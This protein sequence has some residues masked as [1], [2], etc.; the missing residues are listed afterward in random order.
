[1]VRGVPK[2]II[3]SFARIPLFEGLSK[4]ALSA[5]AAAA[6][7][8]DVAAG[9]VIVRE[10][11]FDRFLYVLREGQAAVTRNGRRLGTMGPGDF[12]GELAFLSGEPRSA[13]VTASTPTRL[14]I[15]SPREM[16]ALIH[17]EPRI[18]LAM[19]TALAKRL[20]GAEREPTR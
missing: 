8:L 12:F 10:G 5:V 16:D 1:M 6:T 9:K 19:L 3:E 17:Q 18:A 13:T 11:A 15:L 14:L 2:D 7:D 20:H 4:G